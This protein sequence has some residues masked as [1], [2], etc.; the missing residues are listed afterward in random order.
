VRKTQEVQVDNLTAFVIIK[1][2]NALLSWK[3]ANIM[4]AIL[5]KSTFT[6]DAKVMSKGQVTIPK[7]VREV[8]GVGNG[9]RV[10]FVVD[11]G[12]VTVVNSAVFA[13]KYLQD[14]LKGEAEKLGLESEQ[15]VNDLMKSIRDED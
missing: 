2:G 13:M 4:E 5:D 3:E 15:D 6:D 11:H 8:L 9:D 12:K 14:Q 1:V 10:T 7:D